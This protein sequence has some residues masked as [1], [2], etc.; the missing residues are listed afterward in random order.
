MFVR[1]KP[2]GPRHY[3]Q[4]VENYRENGRVHQRVLATL[5]RV[6]QLAASGNVDGLMRSLGRFA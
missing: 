6:D 1:V 2:S 4:I 3:L 5:G